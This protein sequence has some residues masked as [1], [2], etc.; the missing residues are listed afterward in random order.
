M[1]NEVAFS[2]TEDTK[3]KRFLTGGRIYSQ[4]AVAICCAIVFIITVAGM[5]GVY[6]NIAQAKNVT[7]LT[8]L[9]VSRDLDGQYV[10][11]SAYKF[12]A[13][14]GYIAETERAATHYYY[15][16]YIDASDGLQHLTL[17]E[18]PKESDETLQRMI[19]AYLD[20]VQSYSE[21][22][23]D[24]QLSSKLDDL[25]GRFKKMSR[26][27]E[28]LMK[29]GVS[30]L[31]LTRETQVAYTLKIGPLPKVSDTV[32]YWFI[33][34]PFGAAMAVS[35]VLFLYGMKLERIR[36]EA[37]KSPYPYQNRKKK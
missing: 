23:D 26:N 5:V 9:D 6:S 34:V 2:E 12:L 18:A 10:S 16:M 27:E 21:S 24:A 35:A 20:F 37:N 13:K 32:P 28:E 19:S 3:L 11:G 22:A 36:E 17:V 29:S 15:L 30:E 1:D 14:L 25:S 4:L 7:D 8:G 33:A 31:G